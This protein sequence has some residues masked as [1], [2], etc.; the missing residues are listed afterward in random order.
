[1][2]DNILSF[3]QGVAEEGELSKEAESTIEK[4]EALRAY[5]RKKY[6]GDEQ[7]AALQFEERLNRQR[8]AEQAK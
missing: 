4:Q 2:A 8:V 7:K 1:M 6:Q 5:Y 3:S